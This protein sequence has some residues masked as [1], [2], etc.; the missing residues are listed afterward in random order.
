MDEP[1]EGL[2]PTIVDSLLL[3]IRRL[4]TE[5]ALTLVLVEQS[6]RLA[7]ELTQRAMVLNRGRITYAGSS[8]ELLEDP[9]RL[10]SLVLAQ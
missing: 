4:L 5:S 9:R 1:F 2:A 8:T 10:T 7:L 3:A 6:A